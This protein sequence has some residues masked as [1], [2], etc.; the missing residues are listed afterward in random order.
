MGSE[1]HFP[2]KYFLEIANVAEILPI[3]SGGLGQLWIGTG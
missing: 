2:F 1:V 3:R